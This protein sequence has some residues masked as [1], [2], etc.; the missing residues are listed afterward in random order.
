[1]VHLVNTEL[2]PQLLYKLQLIPIRDNRL[3]KWMIKSEN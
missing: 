3:K 2:I 1:M